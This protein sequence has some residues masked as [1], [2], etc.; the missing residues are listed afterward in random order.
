MKMKIWGISKSIY[1]R[2][3]RLD[4]A[5]F[6]LQLRTDPELGRYLSPTNADLQEQVSYIQRY[7]VSSGSYYFIICGHNGDRLGTIRIY[8]IDEDKFTW[9]SWILLKTRPR[10]AALE[11]AYL[12]YQI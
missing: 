3:V 7:L 5:A 1:L 6:I 2:E 4:D 9:G 12:I 10:L 8:D 11:S